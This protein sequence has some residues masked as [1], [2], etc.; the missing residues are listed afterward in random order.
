MNARGAAMSAAL[1]VLSAAFVVADVRDAQ[2]QTATMSLADA[3]ATIA[4]KP[5]VDLTH[6]FS[7][8]IPHWKGSLEIT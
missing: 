3:Y 6:T 8:D 2:P 1:A 5:F 7:P 4:S